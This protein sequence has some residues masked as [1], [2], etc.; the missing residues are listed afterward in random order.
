MQT[1]TFY[2]DES[3]ETGIKKVRDGDKPGASPYLTLG[4]VLIKDQAA[5][6]INTR[7]KEIS[8]TLGVD[9]LHCNKLSHRSKVYY[10]RTISS[11]DIMC[12]GLISYKS[13]LGDYRD[14]IDGDSTMF[15]NKCAMY[16]LERVGAFMIEKGIPTGN[17]SVIFEDGH[18][19]YAPFRSF[20][21]ACQNQPFNKNAKALSRLEVSKITAAPKTTEPLLQIADLIANGLF[22]CVNKSENNYY[23]PETR[24]I[25]ELRRRFYHHPV[26]KNIVGHGI[27]P[28][29]ALRDLNLDGEISTFF[30]TLK[31][32]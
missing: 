9:F 14:R 12:F 22:N 1:Y 21:K 25:R 8:S 13:T 2:I 29:H 26:T 15:F 27:K 30:S 6:Q 28:V 19:E 20:V 3:G 7:L 4:G 18:F 32:S 31:A 5:N 10:A 17:V 16:L 11:E 24:Y 23:I